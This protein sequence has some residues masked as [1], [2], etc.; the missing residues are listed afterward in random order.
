MGGWNTNVTVFKSSQLQTRDLGCTHL[1]SH[2]A[3]R[4]PVLGTDQPLS[5]WRVHPNSWYYHP[6]FTE[7]DTQ[8]QRGVQFAWGHKLCQVS[9]TPKSIS[10]CGISAAAGGSVLYWFLPEVRLTMEKLPTIERQIYWVE[11]NSDQDHCWFQF[12]YFLSGGFGASHFPFLSISFLI[13]Q[14]GM[15]G[16]VLPL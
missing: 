13:C 3:T 16:P 14:T 9:R 12:C 7:E 15:R 2:L 1:R 8:A 6:H 4:Q 11:T 5:S 10:L